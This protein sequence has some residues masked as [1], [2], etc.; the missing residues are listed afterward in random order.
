[1]ESIMK[2][3]AVMWIFIALSVLLFIA[4]KCDNGNGPKPPAARP[5]TLLEPKGGTGV[6]FHVGDTVMI[7]WSVNNNILDSDKVA[8][9]GL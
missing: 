9:V 5:L 3:T 1:M 8:S 2:K 4:V 6:Q 7:R